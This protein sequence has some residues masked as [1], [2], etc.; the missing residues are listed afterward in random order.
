MFKTIMN[1][2]DS[3]FARDPAARSR[4]EILLCYPG[5]HAIIIHRFSHFLWRNHLKLLGRFIS[6][7]GRFITGIEIHPGAKI[8][9]RLFIDHG[10]GVVIGETATIGDDVTIYHDVTLGGTSLAA[11]LRHPQI[12]NGVIIG[13][14]AQLLG[15]IKVGNNARVGSNAVVVKDVEDG[16]TVV[17]VPARVVI[18]VPE[19]QANEKTF[20][21]YG[22]P[23]NPE[24]DPLLSMIEQ[25]QAEIERLTRRIDDM[26]NH[27]GELLITARKWEIK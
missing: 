17:G 6:T 15:P 24:A 5:V 12:G 22:E 3:V 13:A 10:I 1:D 9:A 23:K 25:L 4:L 21:A 7:I 16:K 2:I 11:G 26:E 18:E 14:G 20:D 27:N 8:G 19:P